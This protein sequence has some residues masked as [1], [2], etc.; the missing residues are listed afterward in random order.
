MDVRLRIQTCKL[1][2]QMDEHPEYADLLGLK[3]TSVLHVKNRRNENGYYQNYCI[4]SRSYHQ[5]TF[6]SNSLF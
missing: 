4:D 3:N 6:N 5:Y 2:E 1:I